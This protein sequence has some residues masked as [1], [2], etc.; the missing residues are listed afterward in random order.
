MA[1]R[2]SAQITITDVADGESVLGPRTVRVPVFNGPLSSAPTNPSA[3][4]YDFDSNLFTGLS[5]G[6][7]ETPIEVTVTN[8]NDLYYTATLLVQELTYEGSQT[9][10][11]L[12]QPGVY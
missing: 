5:P 11:A 10:T 8:T 2:G 4:G 9:I 6:W 1:R 12:G 3:T 7:Q